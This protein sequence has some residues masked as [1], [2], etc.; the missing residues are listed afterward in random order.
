MRELVEDAWARAVPK[1]VADEYALEQG[2]VEPAA[3]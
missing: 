3:G 1:H 2:Y